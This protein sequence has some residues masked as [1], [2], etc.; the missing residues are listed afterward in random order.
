M[1]F[2]DMYF[3]TPQLS[4]Y[5]NN[6]DVD[7]QIPDEI[8]SAI[9][10]GMQMNFWEYNRDDQPFYEAIID[11]HQSLDLHTVVCGGIYN[12]FGFGVNYGIA[13]R[14]SNAL[15]NASKKKEIKEVFLTHWGDD[16]TE[17]NI[18]STMLGWQL[19]AEHGY[20]RELDEEKLKKRFKFCTG[21]NFDDYNAIKYL[22]EVP[23]VS[24]DNTNM[25]NPSKYLLW[26][27]ILA[28]LFDKNI[29]GLNLNRSLCGNGRADARKHRT[30]RR[31]RSRFR[32]VGE[33]MLR[34]IH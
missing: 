10:K 8:V 3:R 28:G 4:G 11:K 33:S 21:G 32:F 9:P 29:E 16:G 6:Y 18:F 19:Y 22:D 27:N 34:I 24:E 30:Q 13:F 20:A 1:M 17:S 23:G 5:G 25:C 7:A 26:Q 2:S 31:I 15:L 14:A 12:C